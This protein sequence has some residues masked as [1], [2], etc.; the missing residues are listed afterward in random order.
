MK[1]DMLMTT[2]DPIYREF[3]KDSVKSVES[4]I[5]HA[6]KM[7]KRKAAKTIQ[8]RIEI[9]VRD[10]EL[11]TPHSVNADLP[12]EERQV[13]RVL[14]ADIKEAIPTLTSGLTDILLK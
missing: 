1:V 5:E 6:S 11:L 7:D 13:L 12:G 2:Y 10:I 14:V 3:A 8:R 9:L 4:C